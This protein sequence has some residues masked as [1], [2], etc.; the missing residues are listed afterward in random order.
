LRSIGPVLCK[1]D[2]SP[3][4]EPLSTLGIRLDKQSIGPWYS[5]NDEIYCKLEA[6]CKK[7]KDQSI[8]SINAKYQ[9]KDY[10]SV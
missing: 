6:I 4:E 8:C 7:D 5:L 3:F 1:L 9:Y 2:L 10:K